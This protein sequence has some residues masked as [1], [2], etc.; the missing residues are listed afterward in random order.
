M[1][2][3]H[4]ARTLASQGHRVLFLDPPEPGRQLT[5]EPIPEHPGLERVRAP[6]VAPGLRRMPGRLRR[7][8]EHR[9]LRR[10]ERLAGCR[11]EVIWL[12]ENS[13]FFDLRF[14]GSR[15]KIYHQ[16]DL[17][18]VFHPGIAAKTAD[19][20]FCTSELILKRLL[21][22]NP[23]CYRLQ[24]GV[25][26]VSDFIELSQAEQQ[27]FSSSQIQAMYVGNLEMAYLDCELLALVVR[28][29]PQVMFHFVG[30]YCQQGLLRC[31]VKNQPNVFWW[32]KVCSALIPLLLKRANV[33]MVCYRESRHQDQSNPHKMMEYFASGRTVVAT[34]TDE[35]K[36]HSD[37]LAMSEAG[38]NAGYPGLFARVIAQ[39]NVYNSSERMAERRAFA[40][41]HTYPRQLE[42]IQ[43]RLLQHGFSLN[44]RSNSSKLL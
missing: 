43:V 4:Y 2:K 14:A 9:W 33:L 18:Q 13:R 15:L 22:H 25:A 1:S 41:D 27:R 38:S 7:W 23:R 31:Q 21:P 20:C 35:Y 42:R 24:H 12:F 6:R 26:P 28:Q 36:K 3:H 8:L 19:I 30:G 37:L 5:L 17:N 32:G 11:I 40:A 34:Y 10:L 29:N 16:V 39:L 44:V